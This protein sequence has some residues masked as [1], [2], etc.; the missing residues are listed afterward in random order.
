M[1][2]SRTTDRL[3]H[4]LSL[5]WV[6][7]SVLFL[8]LPAQGA[9]A[10]P[11]PAVST[12]GAA[13]PAPTPPGPLLTGRLL[14][15]AGEPLA[16]ARVEVL[17]G[18][19]PEIF[20]QAW[21]LDGREP[22]A[23]AVTTTD[24][25]GFYRLAV[26]EVGVWRLR[27]EAP[28]RAPDHAPHHGRLEEERMVAL[29]VQDLPPLRLPRGRTLTIR[30]VDDDGRPVTGARVLARVPE[31][32]RAEGSPARLDF[33][34]MTGSRRVPALH[35][36]LTG[37][38]GR[39]RLEV[40]A[41]RGIQVAVLP[42]PGSG[43]APLPWRTVDGGSPTLRLEPGTPGQVTVVDP[44]GQPRAGARVSLLPGPEEGNA[45]G[46]AA[47][48][49][50][51][52]VL[53]LTGRDGEWR[54]PLPRGTARLRA[55]ATLP[56]A[57]VHRAHSP[58]RPAEEESRST[59]SRPEPPEAALALAPVPRLAGTVIDAT[60][61]RPL[62]GALVWIPGLGPVGAVSAGDGT[63]ELPALETPDDTLRVWGLLQG[64][65]VGLQH[66]AASVLD[67]AGS[68]GRSR[69]PTL[70]LEPAAQVAGRVVDAHGDP[71]A[72][73][74]LVAPLQGRLPPGRRASSAPD[75]S[76][77]LAAL[78][79]G[80]SPD[81]EVTR[82]GFAP[83]RHDL[84]P[85]APGQRLSGLELVLSRGLVAVG[86]VV[87]RRDEPVAG[88]R[89]RLLPVN[90]GSPMARLRNRML[91][92]FA[93]RSDGR[94]EPVLTD[95][96]G[97]YQQGDLAPG[98][99]DLTVEADGYAPAEVPGVELP[100]IELT[101]VEP[102]ELP[103]LREGREG[104]A[105]DQVRVVDLGTVVLE[106][107]ARVE[108]RVV[109]PE[110]RPLA[111]A[112]VRG[113]PERLHQG[114]FSALFLT[115]G[116][117][118]LPGTTSDGDGRFRLGDFQ[119]GERVHLHVE[120]SGF[121]SRQIPGVT[122][123]NE[124]PVEIVLEPAARISGRV[125]DSEDEP[126]ARA[127]VFLRKD[128][129]PQTPPGRTVTDPEGR[130]VLADLPTGSLTLQ[131]L[132]RGFVGG[133]TLHLE[134]GPGEQRDDLE[135]VLERGATVV[136]TVTGPDGS[137]VSEVQVRLNW[138]EPRTFDLMAHGT[139]DGEGRYRIEGVTPG[140][141]SFLARSREYPDAVRDLEV[142]PGENRL[143]FR[144]QPGQSVEGRVV[145]LD[146]LPVAGARVTLQP[147][148]TGGR[149]EQVESDAQGGFELTGVDDGRY[150]L[151]ADHR[152]LGSTSLPEPL[153][154]TGAGA[155]G[156]E[157]RFEPTGVIEGEVLGLDLD[158]LSRLEI[159]AYHQEGGGSTW[160]TADFEGH[161]TL[162]GVSPGRWQVQGR[163]ASG[164]EVSEPVELA[165]G[166][167]RALVVLEFTEGLSLT[168]RVLMAGEPMVGVQVS[169]HQDQY[170]SGPAHSGSGTTDHQ[171]HFR[172][173]DLPAGSYQVRV[174][175]SAAIHHWEK[176]ELTTDRDLLIE[177]EG[178][179]IRGRVVDAETLEP[180]EGA[181]V[182]LIEGGSSTGFSRH[183]S[184]AR[185]RFRIDHV[186][187]GAATLQ[188][189]R[190]G[191]GVAER[192]V[193][194]EIG[195]RLEEIEIPL[196]PT[197]GLELRVSFAGLPRNRVTV[198]AG[199][200]EGRVVMTRNPSLGEGGSVRLTSLPE[201][202]WILHVAASGTASV[203][204]RV[205]SPGPPVP[206]HLPPPATVN[207]RV[208][209]LAGTGHTAVVRIFDSAGL[210][211]LDAHRRGRTPALFEGRGAIQHLPPG[212]WTVR[213]EA[214]GR[215]WVGS[216]T[217]TAGETV[218][219]ELR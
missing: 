76:F 166:Q 4:L 216:T 16:G 95:P 189:S 43:A 91:R 86:R 67:E 111:G 62:A 81:L 102:A 145:D 190:E 136:G 39:A 71:V 82:E 130:F 180:V 30:V 202:S 121:A 14:D 49:G 99:Y 107:A 118:D 37:P 32:P 44:R 54:G 104:D 120:L 188:V 211:F 137:P 193:E 147:L 68:R 201:G 205:S 29:E 42:E 70:A 117:P 172:V 200:A 171:G 150:R 157:L 69:L 203:P 23:V 134:L 25:N 126:V 89:V 79:P 33:R 170:G 3:P 194:L 165:E 198:L 63:F 161:F 85:L 15:A 212:T 105:P 78:E 52:I 113:L 125:I 218:R 13:V 36:T 92:S 65:S 208:P 181:S 35:G 87:D 96:R 28:G 119:Q 11:S 182:A 143:D 154:L 214:D 127:Q 48:G 144:L 51:G 112:L 116:A 186:P 217:V 20:E 26:P 176:V 45:D 75:G 142:E 6:L 80:G 90:E 24:G 187:A 167:G 83:L 98:T 141:R 146:G 27:Y 196:R 129:S 192:T 41:G 197:R 133:G 195:N 19:W 151:Q 207:V 132:A 60:S 178:G 66:L 94:D 204:V 219:L 88:A 206:V 101:A 7:G 148:D 213:I 5:L 156:L 155:A 135:L 57:G 31:P 159:R 46:E 152:E 93:R 77:L 108:G 160:A 53:G 38:G 72:G 40:T 74:T 56:G 55:E 128:G 1:P 191:Y 158:Q 9:G 210:P 21:L 168:G 61:R 185:G 124:T 114:G 140:H 109:D 2:A 177:L 149:V 84:P 64:F 100:A 123:P 22:A 103:E 8:P 139:T 184:D 115:R 73:A 34:W 58:W 106:R 47:E 163:L 50:R 10:P 12:P 122:A 175:D 97:S 174:S 215:Q 179:T 169:A 183:V 18:P 199:T 173:E 17:P 164:R 131:A 138:S 110:G 59:E 162:D 153:E 209:E